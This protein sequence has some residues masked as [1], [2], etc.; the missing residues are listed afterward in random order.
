M[1]TEEALLSALDIEHRVRDHYARAAERTK[2]DVANRFFAAM[3]IEEQQH[4]DYLKS[5]L[6]KWQEQGKIDTITIQTTIP[7][8]AWIDEAWKN[9]KKVDL[10]Q[11]FSGE[12][13]LLKEAAVLEQIMLDHYRSLVDSLEGDI[14]ELFQQFLEIEDGHTFMVEVQIK[15]IEKMNRLLDIGEAFNQV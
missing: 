15:S 12:L 3:A 7:D 14:Q 2:D 5:L 13:A 8:K 1:T 6:G 11:E 9:L 10:R 4:V